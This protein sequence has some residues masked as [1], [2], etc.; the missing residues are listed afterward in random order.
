MYMKGSK[1]MCAAK[2]NVVVLGSIAFDN[3]MQFPGLFSEH[4]LPCNIGSL[5]VSFLVD[6]LRKSRGGTAPN[7]AYNLALAGLKP[8]IAGTA[9]CDFAEYRQW[10]ENCGVDT[11]FVRISED[12]YTATCFITTDK[13]GNQITGFYPGAMAKDEM[14]SI[15]DVISEDTAMAVIAPTIPAAMAKWACE[16]AGSRVPYLYDPGMQ[17]PRMEPEDLAAGILGSAITVM[18]EYEYMM[19]KKKTGLD[20]SDIVKKV[21]LFVETLGAGGSILTTGEG[22]IAVP[23]AR[24]LR[25]VNPTGAGDAY[26]AGLLKGYLEGMPQEI[27]GKYASVTAVY[28]VEYMGST[29]HYY[30]ADDFIKR[31]E[32]NYGSF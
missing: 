21:K 9:G 31:Y 2:G 12:D 27:I 15:R 10:L 7:I 24:P 8:A 13:A 19:M 3:L 29:E 26:R 11:S 28:A 32:E 1:G 6:S 22:E 17:I 20:K 30:T 18:N 14:I 4:I 23:A 5:N 16:C 25:V